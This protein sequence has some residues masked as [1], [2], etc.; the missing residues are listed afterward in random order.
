[1]AACPTFC[2]IASF[3]FISVMLE[4][5]IYIPPLCDSW[6]R[7]CLVIVYFTSCL[8]DIKLKAMEHKGM[9]NTKISLNLR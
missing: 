1:M 5:Y 6:Q 7:F 9:F 2:N 8:C 4:N 3:I